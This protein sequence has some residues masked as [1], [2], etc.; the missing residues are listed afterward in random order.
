MANAIPFPKDTGPRAGGGKIVDRAKHGG[1]LL[2]RVSE[3]ELMDVPLRARAYAEAD[4]SEPN[5]KFIALFSD[6]FPAFNGQHILDLG[7]GPADITL[8]LAARYPQAKATGLDGSGSMLEIARAPN[9]CAE[10]RKGQGAQR[11]A[12]QR[13]TSAQSNATPPGV[14]I[15]EARQRSASTRWPPR[16]IVGLLVGLEGDR[17]SF[18]CHPEIEPAPNFAIIARSSKGAGASKSSL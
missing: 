13:A 1:K 5:S 11:Y 14:N 17:N 7:C 4:F 10:D 6:K 18:R 15:G 2:K 16:K 12:P 3:E 8:R 9:A